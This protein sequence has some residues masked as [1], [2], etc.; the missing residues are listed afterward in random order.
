[1]GIYWKPN[2]SGDLE[3]YDAKVGATAT[4]LRSMAVIG[5]G[6][7][8]P[9]ITVFGLRAADGKLWFIRISAT[10]AISAATARP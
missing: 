7:T 1:M 6:T 4:S 8:D 9:D 5:R 3:F 10:G 2:D